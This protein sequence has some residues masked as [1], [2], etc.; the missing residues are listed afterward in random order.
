MPISQ[1][2]YLDPTLRRRTLPQ[3]SSPV[4]ELL[5]PLISGGFKHP[6]KGP[7]QSFAMQQRCK[8]SSQEKDFTG[9]L[10]VPQYLIGEGGMR[11]NAK[12][13]AKWRGKHQKSSKCRSAWKSTCMRAPPASN[14]QR[15]L[16]LTQVDFRA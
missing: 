7:T 3:P 16:R 13:R 12:R 5:K 14:G 6:A 9:E 2:L 1:V 8:W 4:R 10:F 15:I 11:P